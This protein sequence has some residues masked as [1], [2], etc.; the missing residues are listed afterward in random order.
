MRCEYCIFWEYTAE[1]FTE[2]MHVCKK[3]TSG[4]EGEFRIEGDDTLC[5]VL[6]GAEFG[7]PLGVAKADQTKL[8]DELTTKNEVLKHL[9][10]ELEKVKAAQKSMTKAEILA[11]VLG[12]KE[13]IG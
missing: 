7:C 5:Q 3:L 10:D 1:Q 6:T 8:V 13:K 4:S 9:Q 2:K 12:G 11:S